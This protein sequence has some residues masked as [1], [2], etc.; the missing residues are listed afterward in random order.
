MFLKEVRRRGRGK[1][2]RRAV[3]DVPIDLRSAEIKPRPSPAR[4]RLLG[5]ADISAGRCGFGCGQIKT[6]GRNVKGGSPRRTQEPA[7]KD[8]VWKRTG[9]CS[10]RVKRRKTEEH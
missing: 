8:G 2:R 7:G 9:T 10:A 6:R 1:V 3:G 5:Q 4:P